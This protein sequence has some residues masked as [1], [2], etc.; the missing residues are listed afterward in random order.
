VPQ[1]LVA[2]DHQKG[3]HVL[4]GMRWFWENKVK[5]HRAPWCFKWPIFRGSNFASDKSFKTL[6]INHSAA[7]RGSSGI[8]LGKNTY[9]LYTHKMELYMGDK[10][11]V[12][13]NI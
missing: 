8:G 13:Y 6:G 9:R 4:H 3:I 5:L 2:M 1:K 7:A 11:I 10:M 12:L